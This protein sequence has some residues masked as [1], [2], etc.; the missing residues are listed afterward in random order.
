MAALSNSTVAPKPWVLNSFYG[1]LHDA[2]SVITNCLQQ[3]H[4]NERTLVIK[5]CL[6]TDGQFDEQINIGPPWC[7]DRQASQVKH[8]NCHC[9]L[10]ELAQGIT[11]KSRFR[12]LIYLY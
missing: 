4:R 6:G 7:W 12:V 2:T 9:L 8:I 5:F 11:A 3:S 10:R 1:T